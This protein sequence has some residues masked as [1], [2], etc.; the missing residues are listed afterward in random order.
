MKNLFIH[1][2][3][4][5]FIHYPL[6]FFLYPKNMYLILKDGTELKGESFGAENDT[7]GELVFTTGMVGY[8][9]CFTDPSFHGQILVMTYP[10]IGNYGVPDDELRNNDTGLK[11]FFEHSRPWIKGLIVSEYSEN[12]SHW[13]AKDS[14]SNWLKK[15]NI[16]ALQGIDTRQLTQ[17]LREKGTTLGKI[18]Q[19]KKSKIAF[20]DPNERNLVA[21]ISI[22]EPKFYKRGKKHIVFIDTGA[23]NNI[24]R[25][26]LKRNISVTQVPWNYDIFQDKTK[27][28]GVFIANGPGDP[29]TIHETHQII[30]KA[31]EKKIPTFGICLGNQVIAI[32]AGAKTYKMKYGHRGQ[33]QPC[34]DLETER[35]YLTVQNHGFTIDDKTLPKDWKIWFKNANDGTVEGIKHKNLP[36]MSV[37]FHPESS[38][39][40]KDTEY[41]FDEFIKMI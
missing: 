1:R 21:E 34:I 17:Y 32:A 15:Y 9:E 20:E 4:Q 3:K 25:N 38:P 31:F 19:S 33:N 11:E 41:L 36:F 28:D 5:N 27:Y 39:G 22:K 7:N 23:K 12:Y 24:I 6:S 2:I 40:P 26:F 37:Q 30:K 29:E 18:V 10:L 16:P 8:P 13:Q 35:C 14:L